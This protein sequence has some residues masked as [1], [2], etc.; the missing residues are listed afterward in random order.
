LHQKKFL[1]VPRWMDY[2][3]LRVADHDDVVVAQYRLLKFAIAY[4][5]AG[6][7]AKLRFIILLSST[8]DYFYWT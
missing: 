3:G 7:L 2:Y 5:A 8:K 4:T 6:E 1:N